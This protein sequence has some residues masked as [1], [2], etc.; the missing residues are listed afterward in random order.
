M[1]PLTG[2]TL[3][4]MVEQLATHPWSAAELDELVAPRFG[5]ITGFQGLLTELEALRRLDLGE[6]PPAGPLRFAKSGP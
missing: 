6:T 4:R 2:D 1:K 5:I 3:G